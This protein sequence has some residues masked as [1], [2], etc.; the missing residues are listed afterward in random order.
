MHSLEA[1]ALHSHVQVPAIGTYIGSLLVFDGA[2]SY[3]YSPL[4]NEI[5]VE[6]W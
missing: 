1:A 2:I 3:F 6:K 5:S 4:K